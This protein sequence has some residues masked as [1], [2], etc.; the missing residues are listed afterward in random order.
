MLLPDTVSPHPFSWH[1]NTGQWFEL[2]LTYTLSCKYWIPDNGSSCNWHTLWVANTE[3]FHLILVPLQL[4]PNSSS[5]C[6]WYTLR[7]A[8]TKCFWLIMYYPFSCN[9]IVVWVAIDVHFELQIPSFRILPR[10]W[11]HKLQLVHDTSCN[12]SVYRVAPWVLVELQSKRF[13]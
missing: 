5:S 9:R 11:W 13:E 1:L 12:W 2:Q 8:N 7:V 4:Q 3:R 6:N 10:E